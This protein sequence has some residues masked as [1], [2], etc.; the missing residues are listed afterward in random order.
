MIALLGYEGPFCLRKQDE[1]YLHPL[2]QPSSRGSTASHSTTSAAPM[3]HGPAT[4]SPPAFAVK[5]LLD[6]PTFQA[7]ITRVHETPQSLAVKGPMDVASFE[8]AITRVRE[9]DSSA[10]SA[11][12][13]VKSSLNGDERGLSM[14]FMVPRQQESS[15][16]RGSF[17]PL[18]RRRPLLKH[19]LT[20]STIA[21]PDSARSNRR[22]EEA[23]GK[24]PRLTGATGADPLF[25]VC[26]SQK[27]EVLTDQPFARFPVFDDTPSTS[28]SSDSSPSTDLSNTLQAPSS[29]KITIADLLSD[30][31]QPGP[32]REL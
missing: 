17:S 29:R 13:G 10:E 11:R 14:D 18:L 27:S 25:F 31:P 21:F 1:P 9:A 26:S 3:N 32:P 28:T 6:M 20:T 23:D 7:A 19:R 22:S 16:K 8:A 5:G 30:S 15:V 2:R 4:V 24:R 12:E